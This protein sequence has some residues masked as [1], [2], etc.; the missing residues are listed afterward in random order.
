MDYASADTL[1]D[2]LLVEDD[3]SIRDSL[4][5]Y[6][7]HFGHRVTTATNG[8]EGLAHLVRSRCDVV[9]SDVMMPEMN[10][11]A[12]LDEARKARPD[13][14]VVLITG[15]TDLKIAIEAMK[16][17][18]ADFLTKPFPFDALRKVLAGVSRRESS[19]RSASADA[20]ASLVRRIRDLSSLYA[21]TESLQESAPDLDIFRFLVEMARKITAAGAAAFYV[22][23][24]D[25]RVFYVKSHA[26]PAPVRIATGTTFRAGLSERIFESERPLVLDGDDAAALWRPILRDG[27]AAEVGTALAAPLIVRGERFGIL[28]VYQGPSA[29]VF[30][31]ADA[32]FFH[33]LLRKAALHIENTALYE[34]LYTNLVNTLNSLVQAIEARD[35]YTRYHSQ[36]VTS[37]A[38]GIAQ[39]I[40]CPERDV[41]SLRFAA[42]LHDIGK[43]GVS[44]AVLLKPGKF[45]DEEFATIKTHPGLGAKILEPLGLLPPER[46][47]ILHHH[48]RWDGKGYPDG[49]R[50]Q[51]I[52][53]L[54]R[55]VT[56]A[57]AYDAMTS[58]RVYRGART[59][60]E[61]IDEIVR[62]SYAQFDG[63]I[64]DGLITFCAQNKE[65]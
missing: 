51:D 46:A 60:Q 15:Y 65:I 23:D 29:R 41:D 18:A 55:I 31:A 2:V 45:T 12:F 64:V 47:I 27:I 59:H 37:Y 20:D 16:K 43:I 58:D 6:L 32:D 39:A 30:D 21:I 35:P 44:D 1:L 3:E 36:R 61:A 9:I 38:C 54:A 5:R 34:S 24:P 8:R 49:L 14:A 7:G 48:E 4:G 52:P 57:D 28:T 62:M 42:P 26:G 53:F 13:V 50:G 25:T 10:G 17:G 63:H 22:C 56:V 40:G 19:V 11:I 33:I